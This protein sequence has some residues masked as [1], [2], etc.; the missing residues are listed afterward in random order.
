MQEWL[1]PYASTVW[2]MGIMGGLLLVQLLILDL[3]GIKAGHVPGSPVTADH[4]DFLFRATRAHANTNESIAAFILLA[5]FGI[6]HNGTPGW[7]NLL[8]MIYVAARLAH[9][10]CYYLGIQILRSAAFLVAFV[11]LIGMLVVGVTGG[12]R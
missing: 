8:A 9:M 10:I 3:A 11:A 2:A 7:L 5:L 1:M 4:G 12:L 6:L